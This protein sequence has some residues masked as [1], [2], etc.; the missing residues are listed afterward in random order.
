MRRAPGALA[1]CDLPPHA[2]HR[3]PDREA[4][5]SK[6]LPGHIETRDSGN[7]LSI[8]QVHEGRGEYIRARRMARAS[9][10]PQYLGPL[11]CRTSVLQSA[12]HGP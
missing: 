7:V 12:M 6:A 10:L 4:N 11:C 1:F 8:M 2:L 3:C 5:A 9:C